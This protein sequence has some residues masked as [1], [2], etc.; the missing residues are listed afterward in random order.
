MLDVG[1]F[2][3]ALGESWNY[4]PASEVIDAKAAAATGLL[5]GTWPSVG[6]L[7][8][9]GVVAAMGGIGGGAMV[10]TI[11]MIF[12]GLTPHGA[13]PLSKAVVFCGTVFSTLVN[14]VS[15]KFSGESK[16]PRNIDAD[17]VVVMV[18]GAISGT[19]LGVG[20]NRIVPGEALVVI[21]LITLLITT[22]ICGKRFYS[23]LDRETNERQTGNPQ[24][25][26]GAL[27]EDEQPLVR[28][29]FSRP[30][31]EMARLDQHTGTLI[32]IVGLLLLTV[33]A[34]VL[35][36]L[37]LD[38]VYLKQNNI[39]EPCDSKVLRHIFGDWHD[40]PQ[41]GFLSS[42]T[43]SLML[44]LLPGAIC[45]AA[46]LLM[47]LSVIFRE[48]YVTD[49]WPKSELWKIA[50][51]GVTAGILA[52]LVGVGGGL[53]FAPGLLFLGV[54]P[55]VTVATS[56]FCVLFTSSST[57]LQYLFLGRIILPLVPVYATVNIVASMIGTTLVVMIGRLKL[58]KSSISFTV[59]LAVTT[60]A[61]F[62]CIKLQSL[63]HEKKWE[64]LPNSFL[65]EG[66]KYDE[67]PTPAQLSGVLPSDNLRVFLPG[68]GK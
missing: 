11:F 54:D 50:L 23:D 19:F 12:D 3:A 32:G 47:N 35:M 49:H 4:Q 64:E 40:H 44:A 57:T 18:P 33:S 21:L 29:S 15:R 59:L 42:G 30:H 48:G 56:T 63:L 34:G 45:L 38:C 39:E 13:I 37:S 20:L 2:G 26:G 36:R 24:G 55:A 8:L 66:W 62:S 16:Q 51:L 17:V 61:V 68:R 58:P 31:S 25:G 52:G 1:P 43:F 67:I 60:S 46:G 41:T 53:I 5:L 28:S 9:F 65:L 27:I 10:V 14:L 6:L 22:G 7:L